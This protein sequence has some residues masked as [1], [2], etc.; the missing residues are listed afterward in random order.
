MRGSALL[1]R[2]SKVP[3]RRNTREP[4]TELLFLIERGS[5]LKLAPGLSIAPNQC[6]PPPVITSALGFFRR[7]VLLFFEPGCARRAHDARDCEDE[8]NA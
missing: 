8:I 3:Q 1:F 5:R 6:G 4:S 7:L 2:E